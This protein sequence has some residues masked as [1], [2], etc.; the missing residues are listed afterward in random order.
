[1]IFARL[2]SFLIVIV[3]GGGREEK[4]CLRVGKL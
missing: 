2:Y 3:V 4:C 1:M